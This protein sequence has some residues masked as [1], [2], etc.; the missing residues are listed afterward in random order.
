MSRQAAGIPPWLTP[1]TR[2]ST[3]TA[4]V[5]A[6]LL[7]A[8]SL[9]AA[10]C[11]GSSS[12]KD[13]KT[14]HYISSSMKPTL[15]PG[16]RIRI[17][18]G[19]RCCQRGDIVLFRTPGKPASANPNVK[20]VIGLP[21]ETVTLVGDGRV[22]IDGRPL[23]EPYLDDRTKTMPVAVMPPGC[24]SPAYGRLEC[25]VPQSAYFLLGDNRPE[26]KDSR[27]FGPVE[28]TQIG[29]LLLDE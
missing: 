26:S 1:T 11:G 16:Q 5:I 14:F 2:R 15:K 13:V 29:G 24:S 10:S 21:G 27:A 22:Y 4:A 28:D 25:A 9:I 12:S 7:V 20:R 23:K 3:A 8:G 6:M 19:A 17:K 18:L